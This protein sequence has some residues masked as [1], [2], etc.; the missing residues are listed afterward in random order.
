MLRR[1]EINTSGA[2]VLSLLFMHSLAIISVCLTDLVVWARAGLVLSI[3][4]SLLCQL[5][6]HMASGE[7]WCVMSLDHHQLEVLTR[8]GESLCGE[9][10]RETVVTPL[11]VVLCVRLDGYRF[12]VRQ[13]IFFDAMQTEL[14]RELRVHLRF[15]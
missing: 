7:F 9:L 11:G 10:T 8:G 14:F 12:P 3:I 1:F 13:V 15:S 5:Y 2:F 4:L 6:R